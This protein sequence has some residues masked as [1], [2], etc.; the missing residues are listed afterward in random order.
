MDRR[1]ILEVGGGIGLVNFYFQ[2]KGLKIVSLEP[3]LGGHDHYYQIGHYLIHK[4]GLNS[5]N[6]IN[7]PIEKYSSSV[8]Y[9]L[10]FSNNVLE[11]LSNLDQKFLSMNDLLSQ[12]SGALMIM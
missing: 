6:W 8:K 12:N 1:N 11:H 10:I 2:T 7:E 9:D 3:S 4:L 5:D